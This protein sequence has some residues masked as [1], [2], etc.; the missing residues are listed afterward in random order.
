MSKPKA[1]EADGNW[2]N[3]AGQ[4]HRKDRDALSNWAAAVVRRRN[5]SQQQNR[6]EGKCD[7][8]PEYQDAADTCECVHLILPGRADLFLIH[9]EERLSPLRSTVGC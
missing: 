6:D 9:R 4:A 8:E 7:A 1:P 5:W 3:E 2:D